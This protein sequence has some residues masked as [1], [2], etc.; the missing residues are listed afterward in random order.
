MCPMDIHEKLKRILVRIPDGKQ[1]M[2]RLWVFLTK[3]TPPDTAAENI[4]YFIWQAYETP[5][6]DNYYVGFVGYSRTVR[7]TRVQRD[8]GAF[9]AGPAST[10]HS[11]VNLFYNSDKDAGPVHVVGTL[12]EEHEFPEKGE[13][14]K[15]TIENRVR[16]EMK[17]VLE[18]VDAG[19][20]KYEI[21]E[22]YPLLAWDW[23][24]YVDDYIEYK[25]PRTRRQNK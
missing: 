2:R 18:L 15:E 24:S 12:P 9:M 7:D 8:F 10:F 3:K 6:E 5:G 25:R 11:G 22:L 20:S 1:A 13:T 16:A 21:F 4:S 14:R 23:R 19:M 17:L